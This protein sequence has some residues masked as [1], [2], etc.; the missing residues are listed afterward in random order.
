MPECV[1]LNPQALDWCEGAVNL[2]GIR[3]TVYYIPKRD[4]VLFPLRKT[5]YVTKMGEIA[6][7]TGSFTL[8][9]EGVEPAVTSAYFKKLSVVVDKSP[10]SSA[11]QGSKP[12]KSFLNS[13][14]FVHPGT[15]EDAAAFCAMANNDDYVYLVQTK[16]GSYRVIG[17]EMYQTETTPSQ[18][19]G[20]E[21]TSEMGT[22]IEV[23]VTDSMPP[24]F[25]T[26]EIIIGPDPLTDVINKGV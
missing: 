22:T 3:G 24:A 9:T 16:K 18:N 2:P 21:A 5:E 20:A 8:A 1:G 12:S 23:S 7:L 15:E 25:Y 4:I 19:L 6:T 17:N 11:S 14:T 10:V 26:G 13:A